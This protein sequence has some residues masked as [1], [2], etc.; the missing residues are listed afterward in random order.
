MFTN[1]IKVQAEGANPETAVAIKQW[2]DWRICFCV[3]KNY[4]PIILTQQCGKIYINSKGLV[5]QKRNQAWLIPLQLQKCAGDLS[6]PNLNKFENMILVCS[7]FI[8][9]FLTFP[10]KHTSFL[11]LNHANYESFSIFAALS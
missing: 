11:T 6:S 3:F 5:M 8:Q 9:T 2:F 4:M 1:I 10:S 7:N